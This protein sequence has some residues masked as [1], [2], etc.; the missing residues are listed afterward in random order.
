[1]EGEGGHL[2]TPLEFIRASFRRPRFSK[3]FKPLWRYRTSL[4]TWH[5]KSA[6]NMKLLLELIN[7]FHFKEFLVHIHR[8]DYTYVEVSEFPGVPINKRR[9]LWGG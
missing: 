5:S 2:P 7:S 4:I 1:M 9:A 8:V 3:R 6:K